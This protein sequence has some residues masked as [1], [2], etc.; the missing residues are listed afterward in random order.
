MP[1]KSKGDENITKT[2][3][4]KKSGIYQ[5]RVDGKL[6]QGRVAQ[7]YQ[8]MDA[9]MEQDAIQNIKNVGEG[10]KYG[11]KSFAGGMSDLGSTVLDA[12][13]SAASAVANSPV[14]KALGATYDYLSGQKEKEANEHQKN[15]RNKVNAIMNKK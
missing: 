9:K 10:F 1:Y 5:D 12:G 11:A 8:A 6:P 4:D 14:G 7:H 15:Y 13:K 2:M 3:Q